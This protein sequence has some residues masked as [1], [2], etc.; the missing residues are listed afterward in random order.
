MVQVPFA[1]LLYFGQN[2]YEIYRK[3]VLTSMV[4]FC[5]HIAGRRTQE[6]RYVEDYHPAA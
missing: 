5:I 2:Q 3:M 1:A 4:F 6:K